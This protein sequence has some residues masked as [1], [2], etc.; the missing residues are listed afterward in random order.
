MSSD[1]L[2][3]WDSLTNASATAG[4]G[5]D[6]VDYT[7]VGLCQGSCACS[8]II[9]SGW[10]AGKVAGLVEGPSP[11][12]FLSACS[13]KLVRRATLSFREFNSSWK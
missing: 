11:E 6:V 1:G 13:S 4:V 8:P 5:T 3:L 7:N 2:V 9:S 10:F 12:V